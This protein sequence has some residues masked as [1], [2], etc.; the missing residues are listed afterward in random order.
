MVSRYKL[1]IEGKTQFGLFA[2]FNELT[3]VLPIILN[4]EFVEQIEFK[5][6]RLL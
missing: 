1:E 5:L 3:L 6:E 4:D 2:V